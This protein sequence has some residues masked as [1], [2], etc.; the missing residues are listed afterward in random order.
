M[1][2]AYA[3]YLIPN[4]Y[5]TGMS[6]PEGTC[7]YRD[8]SSYYVFYDDGSLYH[9]DM[10]AMR[11]G[12]AGMYK[13]LYIH[14]CW[15]VERQTVSERGCLDDTLASKKWRDGWGY[16]CRGYAMRRDTL[17]KSLSAFGTSPMGRH[18]TGIIKRDLV[19][20]GYDELYW[21]YVERHKTLL[22]IA[23]QHCNELRRAIEESRARW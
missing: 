13:I 8:D 11:D 23:V 10:L 4:P 17:M 22:E 6:C 7:T 9:A 20:S 16:L 15:W 18:V 21:D 3:D 2:K 19:P 5:S 12:N 14:G 1:I